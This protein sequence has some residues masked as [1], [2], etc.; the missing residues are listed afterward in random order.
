[1]IIS[2]RIF[3]LLKQRN[4]TQ[5][6]FSMRTGIAQ[7]AISDWKRKKTNPSADNIMIICQVLEVSPSELLSGTDTT[8]KRSKGQD[9]Y[10]VDKDTDLGH[11]I[12]SVQHLDKDSMNRLLSYVAGKLEDI[13]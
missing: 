11:L 5:K 4:M 1:M 8:G 7:G 9:Y 6:E 2:E 10:V 12:E 3:E 13:G